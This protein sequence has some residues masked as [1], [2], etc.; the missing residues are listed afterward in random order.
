MQFE[1]FLRTQSK[2]IKLG[3]VWKEKDIW[4]IHK[5]IIEF[6][7]LLVDENQKTI[8]IKYP[9]ETMKE[10]ITW[11]YDIKDYNEFD[12][13]ITCSLFESLHVEETL[14]IT[15]ELKDSIVTTMKELLKNWGVNV[16]TSQETLQYV[17]KALCSDSNKIQR[18]KPFK[19]NP[20]HLEN[21]RKKLDVIETSQLYDY[22][23]DLEGDIELFKVVYQKLNCIPLDNILI[24]LEL[25][26]TENWE[27][28]DNWLQK[29]PFYEKSLDKTMILNNFLKRG[30]RYNVIEK[31]PFIWKLNDFSIASGIYSQ[32]TENNTIIGPLIYGHNKKE[33]FL[34]HT[35]YLECQFLLR[36]KFNR[37]ICSISSES[38]PIQHFIVTKDIKYGEYL[39]LFLFELCNI[40]INS[41]IKGITTQEKDLLVNYFNNL[42]NQYKNHSKI[43]II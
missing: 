11:N 10:I 18:F 35:S 17:I 23:G 39:N 34:S 3:E 6:I 21:L 37:G 43:K 20:K 22:L 42:K 36:N 38:Y 9:N 33:S 2:E 12:K 13:E 1:V 26:E 7:T 24:C 25:I 5:K 40:L 19:T 4:T 29:V 27:M 8:F 30:K 28:F 31:R 32:I 41:K 15:E 14:P 16:E